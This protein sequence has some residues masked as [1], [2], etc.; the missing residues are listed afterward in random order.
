MSSDWL[1]TADKGT[2]C[3]Q[4]IVCRRSHS[5]AESS[6]AGAD[7]SADASVLCVP[8]ANARVDAVF[9]DRATPLQMR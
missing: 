7:Q 3:L 9:A 2:L 5:F 1:L 4:T 8:F 6:G